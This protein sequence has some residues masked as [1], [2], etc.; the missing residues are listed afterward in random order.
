MRI[1]SAYVAN[2]LAEH[3]FISKDKIE[4]CRY[5]LEN[6]I[7]SLLEILSVLI[8]S[9]IFNEVM[10]TMIFLIS[11]IS[12]RRYTGGFH[13][14]TKLG[15]YI[16][17]LAIYLI[18]ILIIK[19]MPAKY[20]LAFEITSVLFTNFMVLKYAPI[21]NRNKKINKAE[22]KTFQRFGII[23]TLVSSVFVVLGIVICPHSKGVLSVSAGQ[24]VVSAS[25][26]ATILSERRCN[27][28]K[29]L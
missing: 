26:L 6:L 29:R 18:F 15:C 8:F 11:F 7:V 16:V 25:M 22:R 9:I 21:V 4:I 3:K 17:L 2:L 27:E 23:L 28:W 1:L 12:L 19:N 24:L 10:C 14:K 20:N 5:G 13:A